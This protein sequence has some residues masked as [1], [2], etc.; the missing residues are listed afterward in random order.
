[1]VQQR[2]GT[3]GGAFRMRGLRTSCLSNMK[4]VFAS[5][6]G[7]K[8]ILICICCSVNP[9]IPREGVIIKWPLNDLFNDNR[10]VIILSRMGIINFF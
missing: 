8:N 5:V 6:T 3:S 1:M 10:D 9:V 7:L 2:Y 4:A